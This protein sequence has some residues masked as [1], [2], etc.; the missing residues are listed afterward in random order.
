MKSKQF[1]QCA[2]I[3][4]MLMSLGSTA[5]AQTEQGLVDQFLT[6]SPKFFEYISTN[7]ASLSKYAAIKENGI[8]ANF[9]VANRFASLDSQD[10]NVMFKQPM[11]LNGL[12]IV[13]YSDQV[14]DLTMMNSGTYHTWGFLVDNSPQQVRKAL[15][16]VQWMQPDPELAIANPQIISSVKDSTVWKTNNNS[17][18]G[19][20]P[21]TG[22][23]EKI[24]MIDKDEK[25]TMLVCS[26]QGNVTEQLLK[27]ERPD[28]Q[29]VK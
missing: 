26:I 15:T 25:Y 17:L 21:S 13:G 10:Y 11:S 20:V 2:I 22:S 14:I 5:K 6:C 12:K 3:G 27:Q 19:T 4:L 8:Y 7:K 29:G 23:A 16:T 24:L 28:L 9:S 1:K 18:S